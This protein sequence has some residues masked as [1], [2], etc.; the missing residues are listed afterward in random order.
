MIG[1]LTPEQWCAIARAKA[2]DTARY[3][4]SLLDCCPRGDL[5]ES[6]LYEKLDQIQSSL[7]QAAVESS[8]S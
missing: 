2:R 6:P 8:Q 5:R 3:L 7:E 1:E 4:E